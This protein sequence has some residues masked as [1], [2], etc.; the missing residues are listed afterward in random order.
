MWPLVGYLG[1]KIRIVAVDLPGHGES[2]PP[3]EPWG[4]AQ[5][6]RL[7]M[8]VIDELASGPLIIVGH[9]NGGR[10]ALTLAASDDRPAMLDALVLIGPSGIRRKPSLKVRF[11][12]TAAGVLKAPFTIL[13]GRLREGGLDWLRHSL[14]WR[15][16]GSSDYRA[17]G[18]VMR[19]TFVQT[20]NH[21]IEDVLHRIDVPVLVLRGSEDQDVTPNQTRRLVAGLPDAG[22][23]EIEG[24]GHYA[25]TER[26]DVVAGA[27]RTMLADTAEETA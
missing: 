10:I 14:V 11:K 8:E 2:P 13:P 26:P 16:L 24:A 6:V 17:L 22:Y 23:F 1:D 15:M 9:S 5:H 27:I 20:V 7:V 18:G 21:Y 19:A 4:V 25:Q 3:P 12:R